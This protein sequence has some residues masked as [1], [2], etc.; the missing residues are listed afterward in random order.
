ME[1]RHASDRSSSAL[2]RR[3]G[4]R[5]SGDLSERGYAIIIRYD[6]ASHLSTPFPTTHSKL[7]LRQERR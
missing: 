3:S 2:E 5:C 1:E 7:T 4:H 6:R